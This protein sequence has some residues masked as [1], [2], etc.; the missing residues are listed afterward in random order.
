MISRFGIKV[1]NPIDGSTVYYNGS[2]A[3][4]LPLF[5]CQEAKVLSFRSAAA[6]AQRLRLFYPIVIIFGIS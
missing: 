6:I 5:S 1:I 2:L 4:D 3:P